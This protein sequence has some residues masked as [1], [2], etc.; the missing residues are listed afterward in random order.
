MI[1]IIKIN[2]LNSTGD[3]I[4]ASTNFDIENNL[5]VGE[6]LSIGGNSVLS[7]NAN[8]SGDL[9]VGQNLTVKGT[10]TTLDTVKVTVDDHNIELGSVDNPT[11]IT[12]EGGGITLKGATDK[13]FKWGA[14]ADAWRSNVN[15]EVSHASKAKI[16]LIRTTTGG[17]VGGIEL[18]SVGNTAAGIN[19]RGGLIDLTTT[20]DGTAGPTLRFGTRNGT[21]EYET[22]Y[23]KDG[24]V[25]IG[26]TEPEEKLHIVGSNAQDFVAMKT[27]LGGSCL[28]YTSDAADE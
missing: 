11:N 17:G 3:L 14:A 22:L 15:L 12:A 4:V 1:N 5:K 27:S 9:Y 2:G 25:G 23:L 7:G 21:T 6:D 16:D 10:T 26:T 8:I 19:N 18:I 20:S 28:L 13:E 24:N